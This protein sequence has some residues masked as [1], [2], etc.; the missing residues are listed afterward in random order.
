ML[1]QYTSILVLLKKKRVKEGFRGV[2]RA[3]ISF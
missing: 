2:Q 3:G 1:F